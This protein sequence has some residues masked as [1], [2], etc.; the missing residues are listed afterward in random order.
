MNLLNLRPMSLLNVNKSATNLKGVDDLS[1]IDK[2]SAVSYQNDALDMSFAVGNQATEVFS[3]G[4]NKDGELSLGKR[5]A[6][7]NIKD[8]CCSVPL[9]VKGLKKD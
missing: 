8:G 4:L 6:H 5:P 7:I 2:N 1:Q 9:K 3:W